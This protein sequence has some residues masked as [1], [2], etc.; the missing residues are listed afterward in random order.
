[1]TR[2]RNIP[3]VAHLFAAVYLFGKRV[4][5]VIL[6]AFCRNPY[7]LGRWRKAVANANRRGITLKPNKVIDNPK[8]RVFQRATDRR[9]IMKCAGNPKRPVIRQ[10]TNAFRNPTLIKSANIG[11]G[12]PSGVLQSRTRD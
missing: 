3:Q 9:M 2:R 5:E 12:I 6:F 1:M 8:S 4:V 11:D 7:Q 10:N